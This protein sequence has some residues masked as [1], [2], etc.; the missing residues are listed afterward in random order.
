[1]VNIITA[2]QKLLRYRQLKHAIKQANKVRYT[3]GHK[4]LL[5]LTHEGFKAFRKR[6]LKQLV[7]TKYFK[8][9]T[10]IQTIESKAVYITK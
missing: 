10:T 2:I 5:L 3:S 4:C 1:M 7:K 9:G 8:K 6:D